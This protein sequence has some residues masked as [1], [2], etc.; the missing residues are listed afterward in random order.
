M[1]TKWKRQRCSIC[2]RTIVVWKLR[3][4]IGKRF[5]QD[6]IDKMYEFSSVFYQKPPIK[7]E[8]LKT[9]KIVKASKRNKAYK[10]FGD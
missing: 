10:F 1:A 9:A 8:V 5:C 3:F 4:F 2:N 6:C 7:T